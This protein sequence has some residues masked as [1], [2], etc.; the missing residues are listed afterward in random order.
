VKG[1]DRIYAY[2]QSELEDKINGSG[3]W[4]VTRFKGWGEASKE[5]LKDIAMNPE[6]RKLKQLRLTDVSTSL[7]ENIMGGDS[8]AR[9]LLLSDS[10]Y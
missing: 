8:E 2:N 10:T 5:V 6:T 7:V 3:G 1:K 9:K 4:Q